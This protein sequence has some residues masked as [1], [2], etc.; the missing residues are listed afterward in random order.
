MKTRNQND[1]TSNPNVMAQEKYQ[2]C[3]ATHT[4]RLVE[5]HKLNEMHQNNQANKQ[6]FMNFFKQ[7]N[8]WH[9]YT[10]L[11]YA[12]YLAHLALRTMHN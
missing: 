2:S 3:I 6:S 7:D 10:L 8:I 5:K 12:P 4:S 9:T 1:K 11:W